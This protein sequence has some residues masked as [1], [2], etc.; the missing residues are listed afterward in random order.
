MEK[1]IAAVIPAAGNSGRMGC[2]KALLFYRDGVTFA[3][4]LKNCFLSNGCNPVIIIVNHL[5]EKA[6]LDSSSCITIV[7][8]NNE[9]GRSW[10]ILL[11]LQEVPAGHSCYIQNVDN[12]FLTPVLLDL[13]A[14]SLPED[15]YSV[16]VYKGVGGHPVLLSP[17]VVDFF[18]N[19]QDVFDF[20]KE[21]QN[22]KRMEVPFEDERIL[23]NINTPE[24]YK[25]FLRNGGNFI[26]KM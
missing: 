2:D 23:W 4:H 7:N 11:G 24:E 16:P 18:R 22:F 19:R 9:R 25:E 20:R 1:S 6:S 21:L 17:G 12:P 8:R 5:F 26:K 3:S 14:G 15:G 10:S 13:L